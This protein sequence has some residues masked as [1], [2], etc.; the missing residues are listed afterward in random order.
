MLDNK[1]VDKTLSDNNAD[2]FIFISYVQTQA[3]KLN[4]EL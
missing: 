4:F 1:V 2:G 3:I